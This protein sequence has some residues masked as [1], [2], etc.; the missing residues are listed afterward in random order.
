MVLGPLW[1][2]RVLA[3]NED[4]FYDDHDLEHRSHDHTT[5][6]SGL[7]VYQRHIHTTPSKLDRDSR[8]TDEKESVECVTKD[9]FKR[10]LP[11]TTRST[12]Y[13]RCVEDYWGTMRTGRRK[14]RT[15]SVSHEERVMKTLELTT[16]PYT[17]RY[18]KAQHTA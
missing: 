15:N 8:T 9:A 3:T 12:L 1:L 17:V 16:R 5:R 7:D 11:K 14:P 13:A 18:A 2:E 10:L 6:K 4:T